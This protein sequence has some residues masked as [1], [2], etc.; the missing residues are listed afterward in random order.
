VRQFGIFDGGETMKMN[1]T[2]W[3]MVA[4]LVVFSSS[5]ARADI[6]TGEN[7]TITLLDWDPD[8]QFNFIPTTGLD[9]GDFT[10]P[11]DFCPGFDT[12][13]DPSA[14][15]MKG[16]DPTPESGEFTFST[17]DT[18]TTTLSYTNTGSDVGELLLDLTSN[19][20]QL[21]GNQDNEVFTCSGGDLFTNCGF[22]NDSFQ[23]GFWSVPEPSQWIVLVLA[24]AGIIVVRARKRSASSSFAQ[25]PR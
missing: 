19:G 8:Q 4:V 24:F 21:E 25:T 18:G 15:L 5:R 17:G 3:L 2:R 9:T 14:N 6:A 16:G 13:F 11:D 10:N 1:M 20:G 23:V 7:F 12:C 22:N